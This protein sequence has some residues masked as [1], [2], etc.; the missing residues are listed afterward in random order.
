MIKKVVVCLVV[1]TLTGCVSLTIDKVAGITPA[2]KICIIN[3]PAV[4]K[5]FVDAYKVSIEKIGYDAL[6]KESDDHTCQVTSTYTANYGMHWGVYL[7]R[8]D[9]KIFK[10]NKLIGRAQ[11][12]APRADPSKHGRVAGKIDKLVEGLF[13]K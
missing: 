4:R 13:S 12:K 10:N 7:A 8:A 6:V 5:D 1:L 9:L 3:N 11:Y 2:D